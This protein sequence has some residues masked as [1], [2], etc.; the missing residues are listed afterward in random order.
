MTNVST[1]SIS[2]QMKIYPFTFRYYALMEK[3]IKNFDWNEIFGENF[4]IFFSFSFSGNNIFTRNMEHKEFS[5]YD[6]RIMLIHHVIHH[7]NGWKRSKK[8]RRILNF[9]ILGHLFVRSGFHL[10]SNSF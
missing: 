5:G 7:D 8:Y 3:L 1:P 10:E 4:H 9:V 2:V 6:E